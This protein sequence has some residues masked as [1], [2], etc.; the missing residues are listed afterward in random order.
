MKR[1]TPILIGLVIVAVIALQAI[2]TVDETEVAIV[3][4]LGEL[5]LHIHNLG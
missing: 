3:T 4:T 2:F 5:G 1:S